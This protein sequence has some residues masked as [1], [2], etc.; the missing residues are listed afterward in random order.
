MDVK[1]LGYLWSTVQVRTA[2]PNNGKITTKPSKSKNDYMK[3]LAKQ[4]QD[5][6]PVSKFDS[7]RVNHGTMK[8]LIDSTPKLDGDGVLLQPHQAH[9]RR[10]GNHLKNCIKQVGMKSDFFFKVFRLQAMAIP[11]QATVCKHCTKPPRTSH[12]R[13]RDFFSRGSRLES[14]SQQESLCLTK[15]SFFT[16]STMKKQKER[17]NPDGTAGDLD[18]NDHF[19]QWRSYMK[20]LPAE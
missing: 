3:S 5:S 7:E 16:S 8:E 18:R 6:I 19:D 11:L 17:T 12:S 10:G 15:Q 4:T 1:I 14:S 2:P 9:L 20:E 13:T